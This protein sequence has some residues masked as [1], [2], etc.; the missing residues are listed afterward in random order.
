[1]NKQEIKE[2]LK[3]EIE[4]SLEFLKVN[5]KKK[6]LLGNVMANKARHY[7]DE[8]KNELGSVIKPDINDNLKNRV[9]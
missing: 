4:K 9:D 6:T 7:S 1:M 3:I 2:F 8:I 5:G